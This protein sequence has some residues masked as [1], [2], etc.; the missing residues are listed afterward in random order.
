MIFLVSA[1]FVLGA[2]GISKYTGTTSSYVFFVMAFFLCAYSV[3]K[4]RNQPGLFFLGVMLYLGF[5]VKIVAHLFFQTEFGEPIGNFKGTSFEWDQLLQL[6]SIGILGYVFC[7]LLSL[8]IFNHSLVEIIPD[9]DPK[10]FYNFKVLQVS[11]LK[12]I[13]MPMLFLG[14]IIIAFLNLYL[15]VNLSGLAAATVLPWPMNAVMGWSLYVGFGLVASHLAQIEFQ[16]QRQN[17][18]SFFYLLYEAFLSAISIISRGIYLF[19][20]IPFVYVIVHQWKEV[21]M[22]VFTFL[23]KMTLI[24]IFFGV[25]F[26]VVSILRSYYYD[27]NFSSQKSIFLVVKKTQGE[28]SNSGLGKKI[29]S[30]FINTSTRLIVDRWIGAEGCMSIIGYPNR[31]M[32]LFKDAVTYSPKI[33]T[34]D[35]Y[36][37]I[38]GSF[39]PE[40]SH[41]VF[42]SI[43]GPVATLY[44]TGSL[45]WVFVGMTLFTLF[46]VLWEQLVWRFFRN[47][48]LNAFIGFY[49]ANSIAQFGLAPLPLFK[50]YLMTIIGLF[51]SY[52]ILNYFS[53]EKKSSKK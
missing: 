16:S 15:G 41:Y 9:H 25:S 24:C 37:K 45:V 49:I 12:K 20:M 21:K 6:S 8:R 36:N 48:F 38:S 22:S 34:Q 19:H 7:V 32:S 46:L 5:Y 27:Y 31:S 2:L 40:N 29:F 53:N 50:S 52:W 44:Y 14:T 10:Y 18:W 26:V 51:I 42:T 39:Y 17:T 23:K 33:G 3:F 47:A 13:A 1:H 28:L 35:I 4:K 30:S 11:L 43:P